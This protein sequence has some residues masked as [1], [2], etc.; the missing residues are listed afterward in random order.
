MYNYLNF[1]FQTTK[2]ELT[3][4]YKSSSCSIR[5]SNIIPSL[6]FPDHYYPV[7]DS[8]KIILSDKKISFVFDIE[9]LSNEINRA[10]TNKQ[11]LSIVMMDICNITK[12][13]RKV[14]YST[15]NG[16]RPVGKAAFEL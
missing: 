2:D 8:N 3:Y 5:I 6:Q 7:F 15:S 14:I 16:E 11:K 9:I 13:N 10:Q 12:I 1:L 4:E